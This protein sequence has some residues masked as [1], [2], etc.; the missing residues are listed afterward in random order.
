MSQIYPMSF[1]KAVAKTL[2]R[3]LYSDETTAAPLVDVVSDPGVDEGLFLS[4]GEIATN[5]ADTGGVPHPE[6]HGLAKSQPHN[7]SIDGE[8]LWEDLAAEDDAVYR[9]LDDLRHGQASDQNDLISAA[10]ITPGMPIVRGEAPRHS[11]KLRG[12]SQVLPTIALVA[13]S[14]GKGR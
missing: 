8:A 3:I 2:S 1:C 7:T 9:R 12:G 5:V 4:C 6:R 11:P 10:A 13:R 14:V